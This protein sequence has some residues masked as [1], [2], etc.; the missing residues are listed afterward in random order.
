MAIT[1]DE[2]VEKREIGNWCFYTVRCSNDKA[3]VIQI[4]SPGISDELV[5]STA[6]ESCDAMP[7]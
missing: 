7:E 3:I 6:Q 1:A 5:L 4:P 2:I